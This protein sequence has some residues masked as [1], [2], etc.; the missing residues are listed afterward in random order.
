MCKSINSSDVQIRPANKDDAYCLWE[1]ANDPLTRRNSFN[2]EPIPW[3]THEAWY[4][5]R[6]SSPDTRLWILEFGRLPVGQIRYDRT[7]ASTAQISFSVAPDFRRRNLGTKLLCLSADLAG[8]ELGVRR[9]EGVT[10]EENLGSINAFVKAGFEVAEQRKIAGHA[11]LV[12]RRACRPEPD[13]E[14][15]NVLH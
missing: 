10:F 2:P 11:C 3:A 14:S 13:G 15:G 12:F 6:L 1:W 5:A 9:V 8:R 4:A 7:D